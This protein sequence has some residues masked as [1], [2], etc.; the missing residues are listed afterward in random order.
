MICSKVNMLMRL[1]KSDR[2]DEEARGLVPNILIVVAILLG[3][4]TTSLFV[5][6]MSVHQSH[7]PFLY[8][9]G[10]SFMIISITLVFVIL[11]FL[12]GVGLSDTGKYFLNN[13]AVDYEHILKDNILTV[14]QGIKNAR[15]KNK[16][17]LVILMWLFFDSWA[18]NNHGSHRFSAIKQLIRIQRI[19]IPK[20]SKIIFL[21]LADSSTSQN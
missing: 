10:I 15:K 14:R 9:L 7:F 12:G 20:I 3:A 16:Q 4:G 18:G 11:K 5:D 2:I 19:T 8:A 17:S 6:V 1:K 13:Q 21:L